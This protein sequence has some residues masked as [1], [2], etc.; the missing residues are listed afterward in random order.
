M[1]LKIIKN[2]LKSPCWCVTKMTFISQVANLQKLSIKI[3]PL[4]KKKHLKWAR[5]FTCSCM[6]FLPEERANPTELWKHKFVGGVQKYPE[7]DIWQ[8]KCK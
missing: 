8:K 2:I 3:Y 6:K 7:D 5:N 4:A 1:F